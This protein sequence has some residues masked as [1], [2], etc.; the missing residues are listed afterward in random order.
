[1]SMPPTAPAMPPNPTTEPTAFPGNRSEVV[2]NRLADQPWCAAAA[3]LMRPTAS[4]RL[5]APGASTIGNTE[6]AQLNIAVL[7]AALGFQPRLISDPESHPPAMLP[8]L[9]AV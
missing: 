1:M 3:R 6:V 9:A 7:R 2:V 5:P 8:T 4:L